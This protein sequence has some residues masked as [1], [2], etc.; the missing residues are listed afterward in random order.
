VTLSFGS[1]DELRAGGHRVVA[2]CHPEWRGVKTAAFSF[3]VPVVETV[4]AAGV[5]AELV[6]SARDAGVRTVVV[7]GFPP[8]S[9]VLLSRAAAAG[10]E[11]RV[12]LHSSMA[13]HGAEAGEARVAD[14]VLGLATTGVVGRVGFVKEGLADSFRALGFPASFVP[15]RVPA[16]PAFEPI[17]LGDDQLDVGVF[18]EPFWR[19]NVVTQMGAVALLDGARAHVVQMPEVAYLGGLPVVAH[20]T[21]PWDDFVRLQGSVDLNL[22]ATLSECFPMTPM[23]SYLAGVPCLVSRTSAVFRDD[24]DLWAL[25]TVAESDNP[26]AIAAAAQRL[27]AGRVEAVERAR[28]WMERFDATARRLWDD[29]VA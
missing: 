15:N 18:A 8:G 27:L 20:G 4:D 12:V 3:R 24:A 10:L 11:T 13:Q 2:V 1:W 17:D 26:R 22:Y 21:L 23:E 16:L 14:A 6:S 7:H 9:D 25:T 5:A 28:A 19:K 29:F